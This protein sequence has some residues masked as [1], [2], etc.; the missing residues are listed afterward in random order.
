MTVKKELT[1]FSSVNEKK[2][3]ESLQ[4]VVKDQQLTMSNSK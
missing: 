2:N 4:V 3:I 1:E